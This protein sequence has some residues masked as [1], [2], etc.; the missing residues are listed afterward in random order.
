MGTIDPPHN[1][2]A[3]QRCFLTYGDRKRVPAMIQLASRNAHSL[4]VSFEAIL[5]GYVGMMP[6]IWYS[7]DSTY[8]DLINWQPALL[9]PAP[10][11]AEKPA[12]AVD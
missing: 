11:A 12:A 5:G 10:G 2:R 6:L 4:M 7:H 3:G 1:F 9:E 8:M